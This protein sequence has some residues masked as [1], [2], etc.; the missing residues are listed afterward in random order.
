METHIELSVKFKEIS[1][2]ICK[3]TMQYSIFLYLSKINSVI[4]G[5]KSP[6]ENVSSG[7]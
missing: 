3:V 4:S 1:L 2:Y 6:Y 7:Y 5:N